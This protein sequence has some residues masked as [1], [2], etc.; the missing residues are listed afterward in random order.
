MTRPDP[1][2]LGTSG[3]ARIDNDHYVTPERTIK[4]LLKVI[5]DDLPSYPVWEPFCGTGAFT[6][7]LGDALSIVS[8]DIKEYEGF[9]PDAIIDFFKVI[10]K[11]RANVFDGSEALPEDDNGIGDQLFRRLTM[12]DV[13][14]IKGFMPD[15]IISNPPYEE[16]EACVRHAIDLM[17]EVQGDVYFLLRNEWDSAKSRADLFRHPAF[18]EKIVLLHRPRWIAGSTGAPRHNYSYFHFSWSKAIKAPNARPELIYA[19]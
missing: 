5:E 10:P 7:L 9:T 6:N 13:A 11:A 4:S 17:E 14:A 19:D 3:Y 16:A 18:A 1:S 8:T 2:T 15:V 12:D